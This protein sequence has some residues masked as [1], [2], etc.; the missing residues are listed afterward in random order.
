MNESN[1]ID[2]SIA[3][4]KPSELLGIILFDDCKFKFVKIVK[5]FKIAKVMSTNGFCL[6]LTNSSIHKFNQSLI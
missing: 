2:N 5:V 6:Q 3:L 1:F 4:R